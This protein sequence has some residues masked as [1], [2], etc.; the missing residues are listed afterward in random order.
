[1]TDRE[2]DWQSRY[3]E[4][5]ALDESLEQLYLDIKTSDESGL[6]DVLRRFA[7]A[8]IGRRFQGL[9]DV[10][11]EIRDCFCDDKTCGHICTAW[12]CKEPCDG[13]PRGH[14]EDCFAFV[15]NL[16]TFCHCGQT[17]MAS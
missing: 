17:I 4:I 13:K 2:A 11:E 14:C 6:P 16:L 9:E 5:K 15:P 1:M 7:E 12:D 8:P 3:E 10:A